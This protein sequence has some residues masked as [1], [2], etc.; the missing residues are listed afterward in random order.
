MA[1]NPAESHEA[2]LQEGV[3]LSEWPK[4]ADTKESHG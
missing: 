2:D 4:H 3:I 1:Q